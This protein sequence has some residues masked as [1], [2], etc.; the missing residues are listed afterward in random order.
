M[1][2]ITLADTHTHQDWLWRPPESFHVMQLFMLN[3]DYLNSP[4]YTKYKENLPAQITIPALIYVPGHTL[5]ALCFP[6]PQSQV[7]IE[8]PHMTLMQHRQW[9]NLHT[10]MIL[11]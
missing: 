7:G 5:A 9:L 6:F 8:F 11:N 10:T 3:T 1:F 2:S 4:I